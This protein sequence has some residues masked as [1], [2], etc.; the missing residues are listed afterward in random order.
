MTRVI[1]ITL[2]CFLTTL[3]FAQSQGE[4]NADADKKYQVADKKL[5]TVYQKILADYKADTAFIK[6][7][8]IAQR[9]WVQYRDAE[10][11]A[12]FP[13]REAG[14]YGSVQPMCWSVYLTS[15]T[16][17]RTK[18]IT[19]WLTGMEEGEVC[20]GSIKTKN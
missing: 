10:M 3:C 1:F 12:I 13:D 7:F 20:S 2:F 15:L 6:N 19:V 16:E 8:K 18:T 5:N 17:E 14:Y 4:M 9:L 11:K